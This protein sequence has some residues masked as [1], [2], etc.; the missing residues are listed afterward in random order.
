MM[1]HDVGFGKTRGGDV[2]GEYTL[3]FEHRHEQVGLRAAALALET[4]QQA[5]DGE[6]SSVDAAVAELKAIAETPDVPP[7]HVRVLCGVTGGA[8]APR[9]SA[10]AR[11]AGG[12]RGAR[13]RRVAGVSAPG[14]AAL[15]ALE[16]GDHPRRQADRRPG[17]LSGGGARDPARERA[18]RRGRARRHGRLSGEG[19]GDPGLRTRF[20]AAGSRCSPPTTT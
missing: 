15:R 8:G 6:L 16:H 5:F 20:A 12:S 19:V 14:G 18:V 7:P 13:D 9:R 10:A 2:E 1:G 11:A 17:A 4:V 3:V